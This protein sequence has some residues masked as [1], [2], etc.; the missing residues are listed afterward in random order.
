MGFGMVGGHY[1]VHS[2]SANNTEYRFTFN[3]RTYGL[4]LADFLLGKV[5]AWRTG[6]HDRTAQPWRLHQLLLRRYV[7]AEPSG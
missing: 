4:G 7:E 5:S 2:A 6:S 1:Y 3:G